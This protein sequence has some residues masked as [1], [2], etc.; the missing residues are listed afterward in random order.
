MRRIT[1]ASATFKARL[2]KLAAALCWAAATLL[3]LAPSALAEKAHGRGLWGTTT[4]EVVVYF[5]LI[6]IAGFPLLILAFSLIQW[7]LDKRKE[8]HKAAEKASLSEAYWHGG[9]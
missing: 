6:M 4:D 3:V 7:R 2:G 9:W 5:A 8:A 1:A